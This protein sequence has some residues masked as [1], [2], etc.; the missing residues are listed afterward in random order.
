MRRQTAAPD[1]R[2]RTGAATSSRSCA[3]KSRKILADAGYDLEWHTYPMPHSVC[4]E[5]IA[6]IGAFLVRNL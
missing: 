3:P 5:E 2:Q 1:L 4:P 6:Q